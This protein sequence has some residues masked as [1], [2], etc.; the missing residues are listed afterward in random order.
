MNP[1]FDYLLK[2]V[3]WLCA[4]YVVYHF[5][6]RKETFCKF[7]R[8]FLLTGIFASIIMPLI[9][10]YHTVYTIVSI[11]DPLPV[12]TTIPTIQ[13]EPTIS[14]REITQNTAILFVRDLSCLFHNQ[15][16]SQSCSNPERD[17]EA[18]RK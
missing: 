7:N 15:N 18:P 16:R 3:L 6:L 8:F 4:F 1:L 14:F 5:L 9:V 10:V 17:Q 2:S 11:E 13:A 12:I